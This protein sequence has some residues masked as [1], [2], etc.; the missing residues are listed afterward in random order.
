MKYKQWQTTRKNNCTREGRLHD[1][2][3]KLLIRLTILINFVDVIAD[4]L[5]QSREL[6][7][8]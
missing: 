8:Y 7:W 6:V 2:F 4:N 5:S 3:Y 1:E